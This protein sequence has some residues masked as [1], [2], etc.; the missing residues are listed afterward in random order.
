MGNRVLIIGSGIAGLSAASYLQ[1]NGFETEI[2]E[3]H[4]KPG[5]LCTAWKRD[6]FTFDGCIHWLMGS[7]PSSNFHAIWEELGA[8]GLEYIE[9]DEYV[10]VRL[11]DGDSFVL[12]TDPARLEAEMLRLSPEDGDAARA[13]A[14]NIRRV[15]RLDLP[16]AFDKLPLKERLSL[17]IRLPSWLFLL[18]WMKRPVSRFVAR[19]KGPKLRE[20]FTRLA[21]DAIDFFPVAAFFLMLG[22]MAKKSSGYPIGGS[23]VFARVIEAKYLSLGGKIRYGS[24]VDE[25]VVEGGKAVGLRGGWGETR[26]DYVVSA[27]D[28]YD[29]VKRL[30]GGRYPHPGLDAS[31]AGKGGLRRY[32]SLIYIGLGLGRSFKD[33]PPMQSFTLD[34]PLAFE[35]GAL[36]L[37]QLGL[38]LFTFDPT[39]APAGKT[40]AIVMIET[41]NDA[42]WTEL[43]GRDRAAYDEEKSR[44]VR[45]VIA[46]LDGFVPGLAASVETVDVA[47]PASFIRYTNNWHGSYEGWLPTSGSFGKKISPT[48][49]GLKNFYMVG[50]WM[51]P[52]GGLPPCGIAGRG[53]AKRLCRL[54]GRRFKAG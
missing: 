30:L 41:P 15:S 2:F 47:T 14:A 9:W 4:D 17:L 50:Q 19:L 1:R 53:L 52:G 10:R 27:A 6:G 8:G 32:P 43:R 26:G 39:M 16:V 42:Y 37:K 20:G 36:R 23:L 11:S 24:R 5:G 12:Y 3:L 22:Y 28:G 44:T 40:A 46:A 29:T 45:K 13:F 51:N 35:G 25:I 33:T 54:E 38:R 48:L 34:E 7:G 21:G 49:D 31:F 18:P